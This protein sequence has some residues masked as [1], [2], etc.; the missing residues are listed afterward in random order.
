MAKTMFKT[1]DFVVPFTN[2]EYDNLVRLS[3]ALVARDG[4]DAVTG[5]G[6]GPVIHLGAYLT[7]DGIPREI[8]A[9]KGV[10]NSSREM[11]NVRC[12]QIRTAIKQFLT[13]EMGWQQPK[14]GA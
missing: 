1:Y 3:K 5:G 10:W 12:S 9:A 8:L 6:K 4:K 11:W 7:L 13:K 2:R 14:P